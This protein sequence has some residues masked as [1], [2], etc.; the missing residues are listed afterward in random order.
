MI[1]AEER[2]KSLDETLARIKKQYGQGSVMRLDDNPIQQIDVISTGS[3]ALD[4]AIG[5]GGIPKGRITEI[6]GPEGSGKTTVTLHAIANCQV[7][8]G[9]TVFIDAE[10]AIDLNYAQK[11][12]VDTKNLLYPNPILENRPLRLQRFLFVVEP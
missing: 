3:F 9:T 7:Q 11:L 5:V 12:G 6:F 1:T 10:N 2:N 8:G 4:K